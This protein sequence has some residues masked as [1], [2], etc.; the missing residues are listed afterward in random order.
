[1]SIPD[2]PYRLLWMKINFKFISL[3]LI[4]LVLGF[5]AGYVL[6]NKPAQVYRD[7]DLTLPV[8]PKCVL[9]EVACKTLIESG[10]SVSFSIG[11]RPILGASPLVFKLQ[12]ENLDIQSVALDLQGVSMN[13]GS[14]RFELEADGKGG[15]LAEGNLPVCVRNQMQWQADIWLQTRK[16]GLIKLPYFFTAYK[17]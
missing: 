6:N 4:M 17:S 5:G 2:N 7:P 9:N 11:P 13:M 14:Y 1:M 12:A 16:Q 10:G 8:D 3:G 15:Y